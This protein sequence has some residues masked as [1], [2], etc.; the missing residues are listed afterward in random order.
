MVAWP[1]VSISTH[2]WD[3]DDP[4][5]QVVDK[6]PLPS[7]ISLTRGSYAGLKRLFSYRFTPLLKTFVC[8][9]IPSVGMRMHSFK[10]YFLTPILC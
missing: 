4:D 10:T 3:M 7:K 1:Q 8:S 5:G 9:F 2:V 6:I